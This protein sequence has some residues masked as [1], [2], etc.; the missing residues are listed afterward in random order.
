MAPLSE[1]R[2]KR[3]RQ[4][5]RDKEAL[6]GESNQL[7][8]QLYPLLVPHRDKYADFFLPK[9]KPDGSGVCLYR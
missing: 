1:M 7:T 5:E 9:R 8:V 4:N 3:T 2:L 6:A